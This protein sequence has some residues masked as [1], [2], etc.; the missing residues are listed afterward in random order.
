MSLTT[1]IKKCLENIE[2]ESEEY[3][4]GYVCYPYCYGATRELL[5]AALVEIERLEQAL[6]EV[7]ERGDLL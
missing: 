5:K 7:A 2:E 6:D 3:N 1:H 4:N